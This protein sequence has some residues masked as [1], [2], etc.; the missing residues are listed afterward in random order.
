MDNKEIAQTILSQLGGNRFV[1]MT[2]AK[3]FGYSSDGDD[4]ILSFKIG[5]NATQTNYVTVRYNRGMDNYSMIFEAVRQKRKTF[6]VTRKTIA[7]Y[8]GVYCDQLQELF[9]ETTGMATRL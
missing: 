1:A 4:T 2:G 3:N 5:R 7:E 9:G 8:K 6:E